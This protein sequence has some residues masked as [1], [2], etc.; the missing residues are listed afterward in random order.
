MQPARKTRGFTLIELLV[1][2][3]IIG[4][5]IALLLPAVQQAREAARRIQC[6][7]NLKQLGLAFHN[8][9]SAINTLPPGRKGC[10]WG[11]W[12]VFVMPFIE[13]QSTYNAF[14]FSG[15]NNPALPA[16]T[17]DSPFRYA[18][19]TNVTVTSSRVNTFLC[20]SDG[21]QNFPIQPSYNGIAWKISTQNYVV[22]YGNTSER[23][24]NYNGLAFGGAPFTD[25]GS[26]YVDIT[27]ANQSVQSQETVRF[28][29]FTDGLSQ[30]VLASEL[31]VPQGYDLRGF[32][33][34][35]YGSNFTT[36][37]VPN[38]TL[39]DIMQSIGYCNTTV[40]TNPPCI[41]E[42]MPTLPLMKAARSRHPGGVNTLFGDGTV[43]FIKNS[44]N[45]Y[46]WRALG[47]THGT[48]VVSADAF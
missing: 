47:S 48:E 13:G 36:Y 41:G 37:L 12:L 28:S 39:P 40:K 16:A 14:N 10:C 15:N 22:N 23:Q 42:S 1:V 34:W 27:T 30:T 3:A 44:V 20:P 8:Y 2:I 25:M 24:F 43:K 6:T 9:E 4:V 45:I 11:T 35:G 38:S 29:A 5:L 26:P 32:S 17:F 33:H 18:G 31:I 19:P 21:S 7:N 46:I